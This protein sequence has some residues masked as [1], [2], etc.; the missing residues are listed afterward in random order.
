VDHD[1]LLPKGPG[2]DEQ[3]ANS[4]QVMSESV[5]EARFDAGRLGRMRAASRV[6]MLGS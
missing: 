3:F 1:E 5:G 4:R 2:D 6:Y